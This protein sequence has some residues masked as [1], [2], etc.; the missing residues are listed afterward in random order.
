MA[1]REAKPVEDAAVMDER[2]A[3]VTA[4]G[5]AADGVARH[6]GCAAADSAMV[7]VADKI[8]DIQDR[9]GNAPI[10]N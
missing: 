4:A 1:S 5:D 7:Q 6:G 3:A 8:R 10:L 2:P 9:S